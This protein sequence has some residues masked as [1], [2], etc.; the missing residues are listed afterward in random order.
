MVLLPPPLGIFAYIDGLAEEPEGLVV[1]LQLEESELDPRDVGQVALERDTYLIRINPS[2]RWTI[3]MI[4]IT[5]QSV[6]HLLCVCV[7]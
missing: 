6:H 2:S 7:Q 1:Y 4:R 5:V 3:T